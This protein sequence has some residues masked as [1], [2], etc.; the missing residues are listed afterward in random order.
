MTDFIAKTA[1]RWK[2]I[3][4]HYGVDASGNHGPCPLCKAGKDRFR[5]TDLTQAGDYFCNQCGSGTG[6]QL[7]MAMQGWTFPEMAREIERFLGE[8]PADEK[9]ADDK[10]DP[11]IQLRQ[12]YAGLVPVQKCPDVMAYLEHRNIPPS[13]ALRAHPA[14]EYYEDRKP[15]GKYPAMIAVVR[16]INDT[17]ITLHR[18]YLKDGRKAPVKEPKKLCTGITTYL[19][20]AIRLFPAGETL[21]VATGIETALAC[22]QRDGIPTW[23]TVCDAGLVAVKIPDTVKTLVIYGDNDK[24]YSG[25]AAAYAL[26]KRESKS[27]SVFVAIPDKPGTDWAD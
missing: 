26:A 20:G 5:I 3:L 10:P 27:R 19:G 15:Q 8:I 11:R 7:I 16:D 14:L 9:K 4:E 12:I 18:T 21:G 17:A 25:Q 23:A 1:G 24:S 22:H 13:P 2:N 6:A